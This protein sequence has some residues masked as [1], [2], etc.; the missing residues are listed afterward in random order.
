MT[1]SSDFYIYFKK[2]TKNIREFILK[3]MRGRF[4]DVIGELPKNRTKQYTDS[5]AIGEL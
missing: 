1:D 2:N 4:L 3:E 5:C